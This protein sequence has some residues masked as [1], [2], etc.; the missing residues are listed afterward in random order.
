[1]KRH[2]FAVF[3]AIAFA[4]IAA[5]QSLSSISGTVTDITGAPIPGATIRIENLG[6][7]ASRTAVSDSQGNY[8]FPQM[9]PGEYRLVGKASGFDDVT[10]N[11]IRLLVSTP[12]TQNV[13]FE[14]IG[15]VTSMVEVTAETTQINTADASIG[16]AFGTKPILQLPFE[17]RNVVGLLSLQPG[18]SFL[19]PEQQSGLTIADR[20]GSVNGGRSDQANVTLDGVDVNEQQTR[21]AF[22]SVLRVTLDSVQEFRVLTTNANADMGRSSGAQISLVTKGGTNQM[23]GSAYEYLRNKKTNANSFINNA[24]GVPL[25][26]LN[27]NVFG[28]SLGGPLKKDKLFYFLNYEGRRDRRE[29]S[30][31]R[32]V[33]SATLR[34]GTVKYIRTDNSIA[35]LTSQDLARQLDPRGIG[36]NQAALQV[37]KLYPLPNSSEIGDGLN[38]GGFRFNSPIGVR[39]NTYIAKIDYLLN[40]TTSL[41]VRGN[42][43][44]DNDT[45]PR[46]FPGQS[47]RFLN[48]E[49][50]KGLAFGAT[51]SIRPHLL[52]TTRYGFTRQGVENSGASFVAQVSFRT[53][54]DIYP[55]TRSFRRF[56]PVHHLSQDFNW[57]K[58]SHNIAFGGSMRRLANDRASYANSFF[59][60]AANASWLSG[61][62][63]I[64]NAPF[65]DMLPSFRVSMRDATM[66]A[67]G[68][69]SQVT[70]RYNYLPSGGQVSAQAPGTPVLR[71][72]QGEEYEMFVQ[73]TW[74][75][76]PNV[77]LTLG[78]RY[79]IFPPVYEANGIQTNSDIRLSDWF[80]RRVAAANAGISASTVP[81]V[82]YVLANQPGGRPLYDTNK[83]WQPR[84]ALAWSPTGAS[85]VTRKLFGPGQTSIRAGF[86]IYYDLLGAGLIR[87]FDAS[88]LG[89]STTLNNPSGR[90]D[91]TTAP[92]LTSLNDIPANLVS[93][94]PPAAFPVLQPNNFAITNSLDDRLKA[95]YT[96]NYNLSI[97]RELPG[98][99]FIQTSYVARLSRRTLTSEDLAT[100][101]NLRDPAS[102]TDYFTA[103]QQLTK[104]FRAGTPTAQ[105]QP[106]PYWE[107]LFP[108]LAGS[109]R[110]AT[111]AAYEIFR[112][113]GPD[114]TSA[115]ESLDRFADPSASR[116]GR[117]A[118]FSPQYSYLRALRS[119]GS[120]NYHAMQW[121]IRKRFRNG[122]QMDFNYTWGKS[123]DR[124]STAENNASATSRG[125]IINPYNRRQAR[126]VS[127]Y[128]TTHIFNAN[129]VYNVPVG[130]GRRFGNGLGGVADAIFG[131]WQVSGLWRQTSGF[132]VSVGN[133]RFWPTN[134]NVT[135]YATQIAPAEVG[136]NKN[137]PRP[138]AGGQSGP[139]L[140]KDPS[141][142]I[143]SFANTLPGE[144]G[145]RNI[146]RGDGIFNIDTGVSKWF[147]MPYAEGHTLQ[148][149]W[150]VFNLTNSVRFDPQQITLDL[151]NASAFGRYTGTFVP[152]RVMQF[153]L[154]YEF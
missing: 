21:E 54:D 76:K 59:S 97:A 27:R 64:L 6:T 122:D 110:S 4:G 146:L 31:L 107:N 108:G 30:V 112:T 117:F 2:I 144:I 103:A 7:Q 55:I 120:G 39:Q 74:K 84:V 154:R 16:N 118:F 148:F 114:S 145:G 50:S 68:I 25:A 121:T 23:H 63:S 127:D 51:S 126:S 71:K 150:E 147:R 91:L 60:V 8:T 57:I 37:L 42:L 66:A 10:V 24:A 32:T 33:P 139:N 82:S 34:E 119:I 94:P 128:D 45:D 43:Q 35:T 26:K 101:V 106:I 58:G 9:A 40:N 61:S 70:S 113:N 105:V 123:I 87:G 95:P 85:G 69:V 49:N 89:L 38:S 130:K 65:T 78:V 3:A 75:L 12:S 1:M 86:G 124:G 53:L 73:D 56:S 5:G 83:D 79:G 11:A 36:A 131:G 116:L 137:A 14:K 28:A 141:V 142:A 125:V 111:Q 67:M 15:A 132:P 143:R 115:L 77:T 129:W 109:G 135:G 88:A 133:G 29:D 98:G 46:Q 52:S 152:P 93:P 104:L 149:R 47:P 22:K 153:A 92:R 134:Y 90:L 13:R 102:G 48:L 19:P 100:P 62:G 81:A 99:L 44:N 41:F 96:M 72:F 80:D 140:F 151:G 20:S 17:G 138:T 18:V 136:T